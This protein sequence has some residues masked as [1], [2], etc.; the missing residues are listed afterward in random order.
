MRKI[1]QHFLEFIKSPSDRKLYATHKHSYIKIFFT[2]FVCEIALTLTPLP[3]VMLLDQWV[4]LVYRMEKYHSSPIKLFFLAVLFVP[5]LEELIFR[6]GIKYRNFYRWVIS[7][8][9]WRKYY[10][11]IMYS[12]VLVFGLIHLWNYDNEQFLFYLFCFVFVF[13]QLTG[14]VVLSFIRVRLGFRYAVFYHALWNMSAIF[15]M[16][17]FIIW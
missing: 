2:L 13:S 6:Y 7:R 8:N 9:T 14:G 16:G 17:W 3:V 4:P 5:F 10:R 11:W 12:S 15:I 1:L